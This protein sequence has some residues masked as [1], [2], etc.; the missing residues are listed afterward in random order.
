MYKTKIIAYVNA[1]KKAEA[2]VTTYESLR[3][4]VDSLEVLRLL[5]LD[6]SMN[7]ISLNRIIN[8]DPYNHN[9]AMIKGEDWNV[10]ETYVMSC[11]KS[12]WGRLIFSGADFILQKLF[13]SPITEG[14]VQLAKETALTQNQFFPEAMWRMVLDKYNGRIPIDIY[15]PPLGTV[16][17]P[18]EPVFRVEGPGELAAHFEPAL[19]PIF[20][21]MLVATHFYQ[22]N[23]HASS[24]FFLQSLRSSVNPLMDIMINHAALPAG[25]DWASNNAAAAL[26]EDIWSSGTV[27]H[28]LM[29]F[30]MSKYAALGSLDPELDAYRHIAKAMPKPMFLVD[31]VDTIRCGVPKAIQAIKESMIAGKAEDFHC[32][33]LDSGDMKELTI[34]TLKIL[35]ENGLNHV[36]LAISESVE[37]KMKH[38]II[39]LVKEAGFDP[40]RVG[41]GAGGAVAWKNKTRDDASA[42]YKE[43]EAGNQAVLKL[44]NA[45]GKMSLAGKPEIYRNYEAKNGIQSITGQVGE[46]LPGYYPIMIKAVHQGHYQYSETNSDQAVKERVKDQW[47]SLTQQKIEKSTKTR[48][49]AWSFVSLH[50]PHLLREFEKN[51]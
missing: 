7:L 12:P 24:M 28:R 6:I 9:M 44:S 5:P 33:R 15:M 51:Y 25:H 20:Y 17:L 8:T 36:R 26:F 10:P 22:L 1:A 21:P 41:F 47:E 23:D 13:R 42:V 50:A 40:S 14:E 11:R 3:G 31:L 35:Q 30:L 39:N 34:A 19:I 32:I 2:I 29:S 49:L 38:E 4:S 27:A 37:V 16:L 43:V 48:F 18:H 46:C 45:I